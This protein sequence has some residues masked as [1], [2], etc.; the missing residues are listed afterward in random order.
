MLA[1]QL[2]LLHDAALVNAS[3]DSPSQ[4][5]LLRSDH[6]G[7]LLKLAKFVVMVMDV[8]EIR[9]PTTWIQ[10]D[11]V[12]KLD[13][14]SRAQFAAAIAVA[15]QLHRLCSGPARWQW[16]HG[17]LASRC[18]NGVMSIRDFVTSRAG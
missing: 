3:D 6:I 13:T 11:I 17:R 5:Q 7:L 12:W 18:A 10:L 9:V 1:R 16:W 2:D 14:R 15:G 4:R 8:H